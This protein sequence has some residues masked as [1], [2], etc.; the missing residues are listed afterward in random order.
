MWLWLAN[1]FHNGDAM[2]SGGTWCKPLADKLACV[3]PATASPDR[4]AASPGESRNRI[5]PV[6][7]RREFP[8][9]C[10]QHFVQRNH[11]RSCRRCHDA[12]VNAAEL[13]KDR[14]IVG[15]HIKVPDQKY[16]ITH[17]S[18]IISGSI[19]FKTNQGSWLI[20]EM[21]SLEIKVLNSKQNFS[22][23]G[24][25]ESQADLHRL[26]GSCTLMTGGRWVSFVRLT[27]FHKE[28]PSVFC[29]ECC[30]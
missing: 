22:G 11:L 3:Q 13:L 28:Y 20:V 4:R 30:R 5:L 18:L 7:V 14:Y 2:S 19:Y 6:V 26:H 23:S 27:F 17:G 16:N 24:L 1:R 25:F 8:A 29:F 15:L 21:M 10:Q 9:L 12:A